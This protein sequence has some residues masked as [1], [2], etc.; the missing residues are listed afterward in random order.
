[1][2]DL[3]GYVGQARDHLTSLSL[4]YSAE[5]VLKLVIYF[6][7]CLRSRG[8]I[9]CICDLCP[10]MCVMKVRCEYWIR[11]NH[12]QAPRTYPR[13]DRPAN[14]QYSFMDLQQNISVPLL[15]QSSHICFNKHEGARIS[16]IPHL[17]VGRHVVGRRLLE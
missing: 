6:R 15:L 1:M 9:L 7:L 10:V 17:Q 5:Y 2:S 12:N 13:V 8:R 3:H 4:V 11:S 16:T 14:S